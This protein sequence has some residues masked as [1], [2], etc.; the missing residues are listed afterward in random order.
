MSSF[1]VLV[2]YEYEVK[3]FFPNYEGHFLRRLFNK[4][5]LFISFPCEA[6]VIAQ[7]FY[8]EYQIIHRAI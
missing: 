3:F 7:W 6:G 1:R 5:L 8:F 4:N 2:S